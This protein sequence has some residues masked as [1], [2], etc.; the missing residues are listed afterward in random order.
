MK[1]KIILG[2]LTVVMAT[3]MATGSV[4]ASSPSEF[5][6]KRASKNTAIQQQDK[7]DLL[8]RHEAMEKAFANNDYNAWKELM[9]NRE[10]RV[11]SVINATNFP[12]F[13][14]A[15]RLI[16]AGKFEE[17]KKILTDLGVMKKM[18]MNKLKKDG[19]AENGKHLGKLQN[20]DCNQDQTKKFSG[21]QN[22]FKKNSDDK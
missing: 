9:K 8:V 14:E 5:A 13:A 4:Y 20:K 17:G 2:G 19:E 11:V 15:H 21:L 3:A 6:N 12:K 16:N 10:G 22:K 7:D 1:K 18:T